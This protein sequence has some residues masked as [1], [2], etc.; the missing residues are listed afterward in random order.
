VTSSGRAVRLDRN[1]RV[2][3]RAKT[4]AIQAPPAVGLGGVWVASRT[5]LYRINA[6]SGHVEVKIPIRGAAGELAIGGGYVWMISFRVTKTGESRELFKIDP[7]ATH[8]VKH[9]ELAGPV[10]P[11]SFGNGALWMGRATPTVSVIR[12]SSRTLRAQLFAKNL[13]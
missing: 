9:V 8:V 5:G 6:V 4:D 12:I 11:I 7:H 13:G 10:G 2:V 1:G 3:W